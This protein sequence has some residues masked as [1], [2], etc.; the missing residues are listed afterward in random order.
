MEFPM[1]GDI[2]TKEGEKKMKIRTDFVT[3]SSS[4][5]FIIGKKD[6]EN[7]TVESVYQTLR[8]LFI[9]MKQEY[10]DMFNYAKDQ[11]GLDIEMVHEDKYGGR[12]VIKRNN[13]IDYD[14]KKKLESMF[15]FDI[16][17]DLLD[18]YPDT[19]WVSECETYDDYVKFWTNKINA[20]SDDDYICAPFV[21]FDYSKRDQL[22]RIDL[23]K[24][25][26]IDGYISPEYD[27]ETEYDDT[28]SILHWYYEDVED[29]FADKEYDITIYSD[30][31]TYEELKNRIKREN[32]SKENACLYLLG[33]VCIYAPDGYN[34]PSYVVNS[35]K[36]ISQYGCNHM[37]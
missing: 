21:I 34:F 2:V 12:Y 27:D 7:V 22:V 10:F 8:K 6:D 17:D 35:L 36:I 26:I 11:L 1:S 29:A 28:S 3:N 24:D 13:L 25:G 33:K 16:W 23:G 19:E 15:F 37:G 9:K 14:T 20:S 5:S 31:G 18:N 30:R 32:I 4:S